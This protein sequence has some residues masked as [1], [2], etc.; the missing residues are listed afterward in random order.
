MIGFF[1]GGVMNSL[2]KLRFVAIFMIIFIWVTAAIAEVK[3][4]G[5][6][7]VE[8]TES[9]FNPIT[10]KEEAFKKVLFPEKNEGRTSRSFSG[11][12][13]GNAIPRF[14]EGPYYEMVLADNF[15][16]WLK[17]AV[18]QGYFYDVSV[19]NENWDIDENVLIKMHGGTAEKPIL[20]FMEFGKIEWVGQDNEFIW[21]EVINLGPEPKTIRV[22]LYRPLG[23][24]SSTQLYGNFSPDDKQM[25]I[26]NEGNVGYNVGGQYEIWVLCG[27]EEPK[28]FICEGE[29]LKELTFNEII[30]PGDPVEY[31]IVM[32]PIEESKICIPDT[33]IIGVV[34]LSEAIWILKTLVG[35]K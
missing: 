22:S 33:G 12:N 3:D 32:T 13:A 2:K 9:R 29:G 26:Y 21:F 14:V 8:I 7:K 34:D 27:N 25:I 10:G 11:T 19:R 5:N 16:I 23:C 31:D 1:D 24:G 18:V 30:I 28:T 35:I 4:I 15:K 20:R 6:G 17:T